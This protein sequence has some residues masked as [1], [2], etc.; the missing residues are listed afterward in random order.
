MLHEL[1]VRNLGVIEDTRFVLGAGLTALTGETGAGKT[2]VTEA[3]SLLVGGRADGALVRQGATEAEVEGRFVS[4]DGDEIVV[5]RVIPVDGRSRAYVDGRLATVAALT[6]AVGDLVDMHGQHGQ[7]Q[8]LRAPARRAALDQFGAIDPKPLIDARMAVREARLGLA[9]FGGDERA[10]AREIELLRFQ[11]DEIESAGLVEADEDQRLIE[12]ERLLSDSTAH[13]EAAIAS[14]LL[15]SADGVVGDGLARAIAL[16]RDRLPFSDQADRA[17]ALMAEVVDLGQELRDMADQIPDDPARLV[18]VGER[19]RVLTELRRKYGADLAAVLD[20]WQEITERMATLVSFDERAAK[21]EA[22]IA[23]LEA[24]EA[25]AAAKLGKARR[26][27]APKLA[28]KVQEQLRLLALPKAVIEVAVGDDPGDDVD[29]LVSL[30]PGTPPGPLARVASGGEL[31]RIMLALQFVV[32]EAPPTVIFDEV[33]AGVG[34]EAANA[35]GRALAK[36]AGGHQVLVVTHLAQVAAFADHQ[37]HI[38]K[39]EAKGSTSTSLETLDDAGRIIELSRM[40]SGSPDSETAQV[41]AAELLAEAA[42][43]RIASA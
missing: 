23:A 12:E 36:V 7:H 28:A 31:S 24:I 15:L 16:I 32:A 8:L 33:D 26:K 40:L 22:E 25:E 37:V 2:L 43:V 20:Y 5:R 3:V 34:G 41:H 17:E 21:L 18:A 35:V 27:A 19:R 6:E 30:N 29:F 4:A 39:S 1:A 38:A 11:V 9:E 10:R 13:R 14:G 42:S